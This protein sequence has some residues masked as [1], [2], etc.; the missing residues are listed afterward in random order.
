M[1][2]LSDIQLNK[3]KIF[4]WGYLYKLTYYGKL[5]KTLWHFPLMLIWEPCPLKMQTCGLH[6]KCQ[7]MEMEA[8][9][10]KKGKILNS[11]N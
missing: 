11:Y 1:L 8:K 3:K 5:S 9:N 4:K 2:I 7:L 10:S 6:S